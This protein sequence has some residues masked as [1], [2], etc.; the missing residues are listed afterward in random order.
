[1]AISQG[2]PGGFNPIGPIK[3]TLDELHEE[4]DKQAKIDEAATKTLQEKLVKKMDGEQVDFTDAEIKVLRERAKS[5]ELLEI[6]VQTIK[7]TNPKDAIGVSKTPMSCVPCGVLMEVGLGMLEGS[8]KYGRHN[9]RVA[10]VR[11]TVYY[12]ALQRHMMEWWEGE[13]LDPDSGLSHITKAITTLVVLR[14][15]MMNEMVYDDRPV[16]MKAPDWLKTLNKRTKLL[17]E[18]YPNP[19]TPYLAKDHGRAGDNH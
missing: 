14:D 10:G 16:G 8:L 12:D 9:Y 15:A 7:E 11:A 13:D 3:E 6:E 17:L 5:G 2:Q 1:M 19:K 18:K 4:A